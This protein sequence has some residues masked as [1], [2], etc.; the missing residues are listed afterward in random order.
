M[1]N[2]DLYWFDLYKTEG[3][4]IHVFLAFFFQIENEYGSYFACDYDYLRY[5]RKKAIDELGDDVVLFTTDGDGP[6]FL[7]CGT[8]E[9]LYT[10]VDFGVTCR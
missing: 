2:S 3:H 5:L 1:I 10:T 4:G 9:G 7:R 8:L 6:G